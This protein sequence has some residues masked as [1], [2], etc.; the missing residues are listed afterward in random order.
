M[1]GLRQAFLN[2]ALP[3]LIDPDAVLKGKIVE[4]VGH[5][6][7]GLAS[8]ERH[9]GGFDHLWFSEPVP[10]DEVTFDAGIFLVTKQR[11]TALRAGP[12]PGGTV[13]A[14]D[15]GTTPTTPGAQPPVI[16]P[17]IVPTGPAK[18]VKIRLAGSVPL[19]AWN[20]LGTKIIPKFRSGKNPEATVALSVEVDA[21]QAAQVLA[22]LRQLLDDL[23]LDLDVTSDPA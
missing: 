11:A 22:D 6:D 15:T 16:P 14:P 7:F 8:G 13:V 2:G 4:F 23:G 1:S 18:T 12:V 10:S 21:G 5:G 9:D 3:R 19:E 20:R 17:P